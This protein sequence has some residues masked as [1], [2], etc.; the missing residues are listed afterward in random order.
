MGDRA[1]WF[2]ARWHRWGTAKQAWALATVI[3]LLLLCVDAL[4]RVSAESLVARHVQ[5]VTGITERPQVQVRGVL[6]LPQLIRGAYQQVDVTTLGVTSAELRVQRVDSQLF[7]V[8]VPFHDVL[9]GDVRRV[10]IA[11]SLER[12]TLTYEDLNAYLKATD[13]P[14]Q[15][16][17]APDEQVKVTGTINL[18][19][20]PVQA[21]SDATL[22]VDDGRLR[23]T[24]RQ[25][26][27]GTSTLDQASRLLLGERLAFTVPLGELPFGHR[28][29]S[30]TPYP[31]GITV[32]AEGIA[33]IL[34]P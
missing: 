13:R 34:Q 2:L 1:A 23:V 3:V 26:D 12:A 21:S 9:V 19:G 14:L 17:G 10:G 33:I 31:E 6:F 32:E 29:T 4:A 7:D 8:R 28:L 16:S 27:T 25:V 30:A 5:E 22:S 24:P 18:P 11:R 20:G 15:L